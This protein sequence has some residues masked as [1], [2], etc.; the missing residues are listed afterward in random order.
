MAKKKNK[1]KKNLPSQKSTASVEP[2]PK[3]R[4][5][6]AKLNAQ[7]F[8]GPLPPPLVLV[9]YNEAVPDAADRIIKM[10][11]SQSSHRQNL[12]TKVLTNL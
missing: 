3:E 2:T 9:Q 8:S 5:L 7:H 6:I 12:E 11:E 4:T 1:P 10:A